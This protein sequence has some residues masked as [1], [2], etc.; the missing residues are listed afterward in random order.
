MPAW[1]LWDRITRTT[2]KNREGFENEQRLRI[3]ELLMQA[4]SLS[5][6]LQAANDPPPTW[7]DVQRQ[8]KQKPPQKSQVEK[9]RK[10]YEKMLERHQEG[11]SSPYHFMQYMG[12]AREDGRGQLFDKPAADKVKT[13]KEFRHERKKQVEG[14]KQRMLGRLDKFIEKHGDTPIDQ[15]IAVKHDQ[16]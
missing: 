2:K 14:I 3:V 5:F 12:L 10:A 6:G 15:V 4:R 9:A 13:S 16:R 11:L 8:K 7:E 1:L